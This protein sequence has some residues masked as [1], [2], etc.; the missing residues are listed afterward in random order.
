M[1]EEA[2]LQ[3]GTAAQG[4]PDQKSLD[5]SHNSTA[6]TDVGSHAEE[7]DEKVVPIEI[8]KRPLSAYITVAILT[9][10]VAFGGFIFGRDT[11]T[12]SGFVNQTDFI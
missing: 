2:A 9:L 12:I 5:Y 10:F 4:S 8:P 11:G 6:P 7:D 1:S 3:T